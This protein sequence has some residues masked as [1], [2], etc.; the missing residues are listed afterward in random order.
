MLN[1]DLKETIVTAKIGFKH[2]FSQKIILVL[3]LITVLL[4]FANNILPS[5]IGGILISGIISASLST[6]D[7]AMLSMGNIVTQNLLRVQDHLDN[8]NN[9][10]SEKTFLYLNFTIMSNNNNYLLY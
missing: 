2:I 5:F 8:T 3:T 1:K 7:G 9:Q 6:I 10:E 4:T